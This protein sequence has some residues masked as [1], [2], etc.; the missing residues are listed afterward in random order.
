[1]CAALTNLDTDSE[2]ELA[3]P[4]GTVAEQIAALLALAAGP[5]AQAQTVSDKLFNRIRRTIRDRC[6]ESGLSPATVA[7]EH[8][9]SKRYLHYLCAHAGTT[10]R[11]ELMRMRLDSAYRILSDKRYDALS[12]GEIT[13]RCGFVEPSHF[14]RRFRKAYGVGPK[15]F[16]AIRRPSGASGE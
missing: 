4:A 14:A 12:V 16:R 2:Q 9:I 3:L 10:F 8:N 13:G 6:H 1:M 11:D 5:D 7:D 15:E